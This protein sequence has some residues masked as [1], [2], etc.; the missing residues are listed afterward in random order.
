M[1]TYSHFHALIHTKVGAVFNSL[2]TPL[3]ENITPIV[4]L[5]IVSVA[6]RQQPVTYA[7]VSIANKRDG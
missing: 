7:T 3:F 6:K 4:E 1:R 5:F 2:K